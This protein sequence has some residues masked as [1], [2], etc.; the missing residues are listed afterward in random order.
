MIR[1]QYKGTVG[2]FQ[3]ISVLC[4][5]IKKRSGFKEFDSFLCS[6]FYGKKSGG[7]SLYKVA[8]KKTVTKIFF[9]PPKGF[10]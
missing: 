6:N 9:A 3:G 8:Q 10:L 2:V 1:P 4:P 5:E 7:D